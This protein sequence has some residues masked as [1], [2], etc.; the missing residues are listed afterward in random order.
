MPCPMSSMMENIW[1]L[2]LLGIIS[3]IYLYRRLVRSPPTIMALEISNNIQAFCTAPS[4]VSS[5]L[6]REPTQSAGHFAKTLYGSN[7]VSTSPLP[8]PTDRQPLSKEELDRARA[9]GNWGTT[10]PS[11]LF[12]QC[13]HD[14]LCALEHDPLAGM[15]SPSLMGSTGTIPLSIIAPLPDIVRHMSNLIVRAEYEVFLATNFWIKSD[16]SRLI[17][18]ALLELSKRAGSRNQRVTVKI[19]YDRGNV[20]QV[21]DNHQIMTVE[22]YTGPMVQLP[23]PS[24]VPHIDMEVQNFHRPLLGTFHAKYMIV[25]R[26]L[27]IVQS[28]NIQDNDNLEMMTHLEGPIVDSLYDTALLSWEKEFKPALPCLG[29]PATTSVFSSFNDPSFQSLFDQRRDS[30]FNDMMANGDAK[31]PMHAPG[32]PHYDPDIASEIR[33]LFSNLKAAPG[34]S[35]IDPVTR[36]LNLSMKQTT[37][38]TVPALDSVSFSPFIPHPPHAPFPMA[39]VNRAPYGAPTNTSLIVPQNLAWLSAIRHAQHTIFIQTPNLNARPLLPAILSAVRRGVEVKYYV[40]LGYN[41]SGELLPGQ[42]GINET[43][44]ANLYAS[45]SGPEDADAR[46]RLKVFYYVAKD[47]TEP[48]HNQFRKRSCHIKLLVADG[49]IG[50]QGNGNQDT[51]SWCHSMEVNVMVDSREICEMWLQA[52]DR[53]Q[54]TALYGQSDVDGIWRSPTT[55]REAEGAIGKDPGR[56]SWAKGVVGAVQRVRGSKPPETVVV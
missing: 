43:V 42:G 10:E 32:D 17:T 53:N 27:A 51:Q 52:I 39:L 23:S 16:A 7:N 2:V 56:F 33:R 38:S 46:T 5:E 8:S 26:K 3:S 14:A 9:C 20:K 54:N 36:H 18:D 48:I 22:Q 49:R 1:L 25:D 34:E 15:V 21:L 37:P 19:M 13:F 40:C 28:N 45:L 24:E 31:L 30:H 50:I 29:S 55:N 11:E 35:P 12:L 47:Q 4:S 44:A 6:A 41:D